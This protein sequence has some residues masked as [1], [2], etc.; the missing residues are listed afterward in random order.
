MFLEHLKHSA[1]QELSR[2]DSRIADSNYFPPKA[3]EY[4]KRT[5]VAEQALPFVNGVVD[6]IS[7]QPTISLPPELV[8]I[9]LTFLTGGWLELNQMLRLCQVG[10]VTAGEKKQE[11]GRAIHYAIVASK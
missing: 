4:Y 7:L 11:K 1:L 6:P 8:M 9:I 5:L 3:Y 10:A 2:I